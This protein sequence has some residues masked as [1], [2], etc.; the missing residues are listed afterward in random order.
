[1]AKIRHP[2]GQADNVALTAAGAQAIT[3]DGDVTILD[4]VTVEATS[5]RTLNITV[6]SE[7]KAGAKIFLKTKTNG[8]ETN[9]YGTGI[10]APTLTGVAGKTFTHAFTYDGVNFLPDGTAVKID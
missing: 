6:N 7:I 8:T 4:G 3:I 2:F 10:I 5:N 9:I 1:M